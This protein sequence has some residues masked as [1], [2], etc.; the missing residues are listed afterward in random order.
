MC[1]A[2]AEA[3]SSCPLPAGPRCI[4]ARAADGRRLQRKRGGFTT[5][6]E[7]DRA[8]CELLTSVE[9]GTYVNSSTTTLGQYLREEWLPATAPPRTK[10]ETWNDRRENR[11]FA[12]KWGLRLG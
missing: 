5:R 6:K 2:C 11:L 3:P 10:W 8:L 12:M 4:R 1:V 9:G 7:A